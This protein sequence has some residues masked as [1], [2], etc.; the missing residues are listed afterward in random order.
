MARCYK[1]DNWSKSSQSCKGVCE[2]KTDG[3]VNNEVRAEVNGSLLLEAATRERLMKT[4]QTEK[5]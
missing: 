2:E 1:E 4:Q 3:A 5:T